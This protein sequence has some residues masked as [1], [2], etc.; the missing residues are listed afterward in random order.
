[1]VMMILA[2]A[3]PYRRIIKANLSWRRTWEKF[4]HCKFIRFLSPTQ[5]NKTVQKFLKSGFKYKKE[6]KKHRQKFY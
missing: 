1:M 5:S 6:R 4:C 3:R 2:K